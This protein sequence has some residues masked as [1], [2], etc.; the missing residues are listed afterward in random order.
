EWLFDADAGAIYDSNLTGAP[1]GP[2]VRSGWAVVANASAGQFF[3]LS[4]DD[5]LTLTVKARGEANTRFSGLNMA[6]VGASVRYRHKFGLGRD[7]PSA[8]V[9]VNTLYGDY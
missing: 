8:S 4:G 7:A 9:V 3:A 1:S 5:G 6:G 2:D